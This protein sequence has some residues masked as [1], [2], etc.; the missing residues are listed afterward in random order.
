MK[1]QNK[2]ERNYHIF[3]RMLVGMTTA[4]KQKFML[5]KAEDYHYLTQGSCLTC[6][7]MDDVEE[8]STIRGSMKVSNNHRGAEFVFIEEKFPKKDE[9][10]RSGFLTD[11]AL[12]LSLIHI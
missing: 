12:Y 9:V 2:D 11:I 7:G 8:F 4:E 3:Y 6:E 1:F 5:T 10:W